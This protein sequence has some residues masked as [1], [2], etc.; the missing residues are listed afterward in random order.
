M[1]KC[2]QNDVNRTKFRFRGDFASVLNLQDGGRWTRKP[3]SFSFSLKEVINGL[4]NRSI[5]SI[6]LFTIK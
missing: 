2:D 1:T 5:N 6:Y 3:C 4:D